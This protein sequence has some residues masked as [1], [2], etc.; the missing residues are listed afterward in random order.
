MTV[1]DR[2]QLTPSIYTS[3]WVNEQM[4]PMPCRVVAVNPGHRHYTVRF[5]FP[6]GSFCETF[7]EDGLCGKD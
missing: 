1:G 7:K 2:L 5:D 4:R 3:S 6:R